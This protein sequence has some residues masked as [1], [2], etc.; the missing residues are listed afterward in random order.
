MLANKG[1]GGDIL[2]DISKA[3]STIYYDLLITKLSV[4]GFLKESLKLIKSLLTNRWQRTTLNTGFSTW[5]EILL[6]VSQ[7]SELKRLFFNIYIRDLFLRFILRLEHDSVLA[8]E[9]F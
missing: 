2:I 9:W 4:D 5:T 1:F 3:C 7:G 8:I 6:G